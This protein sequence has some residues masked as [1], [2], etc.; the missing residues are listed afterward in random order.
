[1]WGREN[2]SEGVGGIKTPML[3]IAAE[4]DTAPFQAP[5]V[6]YVNA[7]LLPQRTS[8]LTRRVWPLPDAGAA[9]IARYSDRTFL[10]RL[11]RGPA[12]RSCLTAERPG[13]GLWLLVVDPYFTE[14]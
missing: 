1:M 7:A 13:V 2:I 11:A 10:E 9:A 5:R 12:I 6:E 3:I 14:R 4:K 8:G